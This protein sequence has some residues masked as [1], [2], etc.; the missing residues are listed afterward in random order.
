[1]KPNIKINNNM[2]NIIT[3]NIPHELKEQPQW[4]AWNN[5]I[6]INPRNGNYA[7]TNDPETWGTFEEALERYQNYKMHGIGFVFSE[8]DQFTGIDIDKCVDP[9]TGEINPSAEELIELFDSYSEISPSGQGIHIIAKGKLPGGCRRDER[10]EIY[11]RSQFFTITGNWIGNTPKTIIDRSFEITNYYQ[12]HFDQSSKSESLKPSQD[13][14]D[15]ALIEKAMNAK[16]GTKFQRLWSGNNS[17]YNSQS[18]ADFA[19]CKILAFWTVRDATH[20][21]RLFRQSSL[22]R[23]KWD[24][25]HHSSGRTYGEETIFRA[26]EATTETY[27]FGQNQ[28]ENKLSSKIIP[29]TDMGN[30]ERLVYQFGDD[31]RYCHAWKSWLV[32]DETRWS[33]DKTDSIKRKAKKTVRGI[34]GEVEGVSD[35]SERKAIAKHAINSEASSRIKSMLYLAKSEVP[36][37][38]EELD[39]YHWLLTCL[40]GTVNLRTGELQPHQREHLITQLAPTEYNPNASSPIWDEFL[41]RIMDGNENL[42]KFLQRSIGY[43]L[44]GN[45]S[46]QCL[47]I[48]FGNGANGKSTFLQAVNAVLGTTRCKHQQRRF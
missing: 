18:E 23:K 43:S 21:D 27:S 9:E 11:D 28:V 12:Q 7:K 25:R 30:A 44:T 38:A 48:L 35:T 42:I 15:D 45:T 5:K 33:V 34:Y 29:M 3:E 19:L 10:A 32:W 24:E 16:D 46:E 39:Q 6:P 2:D 26:I 22:Y 47:F 41:W 31:I 8:H 17:G 13:H 14:N 40:N 4:V 36:I 37:A 20:M 1:M